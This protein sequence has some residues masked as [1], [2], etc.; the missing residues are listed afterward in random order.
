[1]KSKLTTLHVLSAKDLKFVTGGVGGTGTIKVTGITSG[2][3]AI[4]NSGGTGSIKVTG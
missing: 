4:S 2:T 1:M 3:G